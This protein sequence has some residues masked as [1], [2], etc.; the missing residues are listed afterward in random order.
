ML[1]RLRCLIHMQI[2]FH[3]ELRLTIR[4]RPS[5]WEVGTSRLDSRQTALQNYSRVLLCSYRWIL[6]S[7]RWKRLNLDLFFSKITSFSS[8]MDGQRPLPSSQPLL[9]MQNEWTLRPESQDSWAGNRLEITQNWNTVEKVGTFCLQQ[10]EVLWAH[11]T[12]TFFPHSEATLSAFRP[13][14]HEVKVEVS[15]VYTK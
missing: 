7:R 6:G 10:N 5:P 11:N 9:L 4:F 2:T 15:V 12:T 8:T 3:C 1:H 13:I 14:T